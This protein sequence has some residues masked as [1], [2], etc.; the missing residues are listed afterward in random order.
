MAGPR[1]E[2]LRVLDAV[3]DLCMF[4]DP[5]TPE[6]IAK[7]II[8]PEGPDDQPEP[9]MA[10]IARVCGIAED[11]GDHSPFTY[12]R[13]VCEVAAKRIKLGQRVWPEAL[14]RWFDWDDRLLYIGITRD[15]AV[16]SDSHSRSSSWARFAARCEV[17]RYPTREMV[18]TVER[19]CIRDEQPL[20][21]HIHNDSPEA[22]Q[23][24]VAYLVEQGHLDLLA[25]AVSRG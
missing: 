4:K 25:P 24:L 17:M 22:R 13:K 16:R 11:I 1:S 8:D 23:R 5:I 19:Q 21:N 10:F 3:H 15:V 12:A 6:S 9:P 2:K 7:Y 18:E 14:Y 20:F